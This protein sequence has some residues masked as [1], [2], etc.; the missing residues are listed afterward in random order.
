MRFQDSGYKR[1]GHGF[2]ESLRYYFEL[3]ANIIFVLLITTFALMA[4]IR[5]LGFESVDYIQCLNPWYIKLQQEGF[6][7]F[8]EKFSNYSAPYLYLLYLMTKT[9]LSSLYGV[10]IISIIADIVMSL[11]SFALIRRLTDNKIAA[12]SG[13]ALI[14]L[15]PT[16][17]LNGAAWGQCDAVFTCFI[18]IALY[19]LVCEKYFLS[20]LIYGIALSFKLQAIFVLPVYVSLGLHGLFPLSYLLVCPV[21]YVVF[22]IP[23]I[24]VGAKISTIFF[25]TYAEQVRGFKDITL[26]APTLFAF[27]D[28]DNLLVQKSFVNLGVGLALTGSF[29]YH[30]NKALCRNK[31]LSC[32]F[33]SVFIPYVL[34]RMHERYF[35]I[36]DVLTIIYACCRPSRFFVPIFVGVASLLSYMPFLLGRTVLPL[37]FAASLMGL[38]AATLGMD[39]YKELRKP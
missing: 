6:L 35:F 26:N 39:L 25:R 16:V 27:C 19:Y 37:P 33:F 23:Q 15:S 13:Y 12:L 10:K 4:R 2:E 36:G 11:A 34:P 31:V 5:L 3:H 28:N 8:K 7:A 24:F 14:L 17:V 20:V 32:A 18:V 9:G 22:H 1:S 38:A 21:L 29:L 30:V